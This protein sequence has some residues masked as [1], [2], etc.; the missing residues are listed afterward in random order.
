MVLAGVD[1]FG[2]DKAFI[3]SVALVASAVQFGYFLVYSGIVSSLS[4]LVI[5]QRAISSSIMPAIDSYG[6]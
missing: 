6:L 5:V 1:S 2:Q 4:A 3:E